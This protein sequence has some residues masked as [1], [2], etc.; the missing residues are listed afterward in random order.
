MSTG[1][2]VGVY[3]VDTSGESQYKCTCG[4]SAVRNRACAYNSGLFYEDELDITGAREDLDGS[5]RLKPPLVKLPDD[6]KEEKWPQVLITIMQAQCSTLFSSLT[7]L[8]KFTKPYLRSSAEPAHK[9]L[10]EL[11]LMDG[12]EACMNALDQSRQYWDGCS[13]GKQDKALLRSCIHTWAYSRAVSTVNSQDVVRV[14][15]SLQPYLQEAI[16]RKNKKLWEATYNVAG[17][18]TWRQFHKLAGRGTE[19]QCEPQPIPSLLVGHDKDWMSLSPYAVSYWDKL[20][21]EPYSSSRDV[22]Y[23]VV[24]PDNEHVLSSVRVFFK[25]LSSTY[26][27]CRLGKHTPITKI[28][29][30]GILRVGKTAARKLADEKVDVWFSQIGDSPA[31]ARLKLY[32]QV[33]KGHLALTSSLAALTTCLLLQKQVMAMFR[34]PYILAPAKDKQTELGESFGEAVEKCTVLFCEYCLTY[35]QRH[36]LAVC[37][38]DR[39]ELLETTVINIEIPNRGRRKKASARRIGLRKLWDFLLGVMSMSSSPWR[40]VIG[41]FGRIGH[42]ELMG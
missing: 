27:V 16:Q 35:D 19:E 12:C 9:E 37:T 39:G 8:F 42:G 15:R 1:G 13:S 11:E 23:V 30:D 31:A 17:P 38:D 18:L 36:L 33:C 7:L 28:L 10:R 34:P 29:R 41:R 24:A 2:D 4:F 14:M 22:A 21:L 6:G 5:Y 32:A 3:L 26:D 20:L 25:E 40:L